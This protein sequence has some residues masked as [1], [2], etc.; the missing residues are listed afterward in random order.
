MTI[1]PSHANTRQ[2]AS[3]SEE[4]LSDQAER[5]TQPDDVG[6]RGIGCSG[7][8]NRGITVAGVGAVLGRDPL[9]KAGLAIA[10]AE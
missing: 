3:A 8:S 7:H 1:F 10:T 6:Q 9:L 5:M 2:R 4:A